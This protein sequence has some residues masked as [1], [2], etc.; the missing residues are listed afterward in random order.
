M[1]TK[2]RRRTPRQS[3]KRATDGTLAKTNPARARRVR[4]L[5]RFLNAFD[6]KNDKRS[7]ARAAGCHP[8][9][10]AH[11]SCYALRSYCPD[12]Q[13]RPL[14]SP[15]GQSS[16][17]SSRKPDHYRRCRC[18]WRSG[19]SLCFS[20]VYPRVCGNRQREPGDGCLG[21]GSR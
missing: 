3:I 10:Q 12:L 1:Q 18:V 7:Y 5:V 15:G 16:I 21:Q 8:L 13:L 14:T 4:Y 11:A 20:W 2:L 19:P 17:R 9:G 6:L